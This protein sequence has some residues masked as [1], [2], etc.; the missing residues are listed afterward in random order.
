M[1]LAAHWTEPIGS[2]IEFN[3]LAVQRATESGDATFAAH[4]NHQYLK[5]LLLRN[6]SLDVVW[7]ES[8]RVLDA[9]RDAEFRDAED[10]I[11]NEQ[12]F[13]AAMQGRTPAFSASGDPEGDEEV[14]EATLTD[15][16][17]PLMVCLYWRFRSLKRGSCL[18]TWPAPWKHY[19]ERDVLFGRS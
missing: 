14:Y 1:S 6:D 4:T 2:A 8:E 17:M 19:A 5:C 9:A 16:R 15:S 12:R 13:V 11:L 3:R 7:R 10:L 18:E